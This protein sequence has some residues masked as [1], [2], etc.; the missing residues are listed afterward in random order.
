LGLIVNSE[1]SFKRP[2]LLAAVLIL[3]IA[4]PLIADATGYSAMTSL[5]TRILIYGIAAASLNL[6]LGYGGLVSFG[7][8]AFFGIGGYVVGIL[9]QHYSLEEPLFGF[10]PGTNQMLI[11]LPAAILVSG[12]AAAAIGALS[13]RTGG[14][15]FIMITL[16]FAQMLFFLFVSLKTYGGDD[17]LIIRRT[18]ELPGLNMRDKQTVYYVCLFITVA[19]F[20]LLWRIVNSRFGNVLVGLRQSEKRMAAIGLPAYRYRLMAF[21]VSGMGCGLAG[22]LM[23]NFLRFASPDMMHWTKSGELMVMV[24]LGGVGTLFGPLIGA[25]VFIV[26]ETSLASWTENWQLALGFILLFVVLYTHGGVQALVLRLIGK[27]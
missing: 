21:V 9:Y 5:A 25:A 27:R 24:I 7:H 8:A 19:F 23:A 26:L 14:V 1:T 3:L 16:A 15:Q 20:A 6:V 10:I 2:V 17:G 13:L 12:L 11:T 4:L 22:A 18:N